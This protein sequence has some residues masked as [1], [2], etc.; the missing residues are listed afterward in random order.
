M[1]VVDHV[2]ADTERKMLDRLRVLLGIPTDIA[3]EIEA[4]IPGLTVRDRCSG[5]TRSATWRG[6]AAWRRCRRR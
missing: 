2:F 1:A 5:V 6:E 4:D 3:L